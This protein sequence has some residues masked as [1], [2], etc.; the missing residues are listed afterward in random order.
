MEHRKTVGDAV[1]KREASCFP[2][3]IQDE[4]YDNNIGEGTSRALIFQPSVA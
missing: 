4:D 2:Y 1:G 3:K